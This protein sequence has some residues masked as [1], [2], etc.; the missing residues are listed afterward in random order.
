[1]SLP[2]TVCVKFNRLRTGFGRLHLFMHKWGLAPSPNCECGAIEQTADHVLIA[3]SIHQTPRGLK[4][5]DN[6]TRCALTTSLPA[7]DPG[8]T[9]VWGSE[10]INPRPQSCL[11][12]TWSG[13]SS[14]R[15]RQLRRRHSPTTSHL[16]VVVQSPSLPWG[17]LKWFVDS[18]RNSSSGNSFTD[19]LSPYFLSLLSVARSHLDSI[20]KPK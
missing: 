8:S 7:S 2:R 10:R 6:E 5:F 12:L 11:S 19:N 14:K 3:Y 17:G 20:L 4:V 9:T 13:C 18:P 1:M 16:N 15:R